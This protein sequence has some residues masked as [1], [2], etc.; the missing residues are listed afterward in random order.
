MIWNGSRV[1]KGPQGTLYGR[2][3]TAGL[4][5]FITAK[6]TDTFEGGVKAELGNYQTYN[7][8]GHLSGPLGEGS[9]GA[10]RGCAAKTATSGAGRSATRAPTNA[11]AASTSSASAARW[12][13]RSRSGDQHRSVGL[14]RWQ[15]KSDIVAGQW[16]RLYPRHQPRLGHQQFAPVQR[17]GLA[18]YLANY[19]ST[20]ASQPIAPEA[21]ALGR[22]RS[23]RRPARRPRRKQPFLGPET[24][25][26]PGSRR[27][28][29]VRQP[30]P[31][32]MISAQG[33]VR[34]ERRAVRG[35][36]A[37]GGRAGSRASRRK[38]ISEGETGAVNWLIGG[39]YGHDKI[40]RQQPHLAG[41]KR[42]RARSSARCRFI[43]VPGVNL[44]DTP[45]N[46]AITPPPT[47]R[48]ASPMKTSAR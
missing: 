15:N 36:A 1:L 18:T 6:P 34:L 27:H 24:A 42:E 37:K 39:Y 13:A 8:E 38:S 25:H 5:N 32:T 33:A 43:I 20:K 10:H 2:N 31:A 44:F 46:R 26:R 14:P 21:G 11:S 35:A 7:F 12:R 47:W 29:E 45:F 9:C 17:P 4:I 3:T 19:F 40:A 22:H 30:R 28:G 16:H 41:R 23:R 48:P